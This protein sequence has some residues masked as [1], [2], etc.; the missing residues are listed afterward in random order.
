MRLAM[1]T[2]ILP[3]DV[4][5]VLA[6]RLIADLDADLLSRYPGEPVNGVNPEECFLTSVQF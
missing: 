5:E 3:V 1:E 4:A 6:S 2:T